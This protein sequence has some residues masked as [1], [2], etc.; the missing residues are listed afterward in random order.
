M[1]YPYSIFNFEPIIT[2]VSVVAKNNENNFFSFTILAVSD[3]EEL[4]KNSAVR[5]M[6]QK[7]HTVTFI[8]NILMG[9]SRMPCC[10]RYSLDQRFLTLLIEPKISK[11]EHFHK[12]FFKSSVR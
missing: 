8:D 4:Q 6:V 7:S 9:F 11:G 3:I 12:Y 2:V 10:K 5:R 1:K